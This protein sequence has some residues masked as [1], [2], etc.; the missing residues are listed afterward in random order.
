MK[1]EVI[2]K[3]AIFIAIIAIIIVAL[4]GVIY[5]L[6]KNNS[7]LRSF[8]RKLLPFTRSAVIPENKDTLKF[9][10]KSSGLMEAGDPFYEAF[11]DIE[12]E[13]DPIE[14][15]FE[16]DDLE[17]YRDNAGPMQPFEFPELNYGTGTGTGAPVAFDG[18]PFANTPGTPGLPDF[19]QQNEGAIA[20][21]QPTVYLPSVD[22]QNVHD[23]GVNK[24]IRKI[25]N[26]IGLKMGSGTR[27]VISKL[28]K[29]IPKGR[30][31][32]RIGKVLD[33]IELRNAN[34]SNL[35]NASE[36]DVLSTVYTQALKNDNIRDMMFQQ[37]E[38]AIDNGTVVCPTGVVNR[39]STALIVETP[40]QFPKTKEQ[41][42][43]EML[44]SASFVRSQ[45]EKDSSYEYMS[46]PEQSTR[47]K[48]NL[49]DKLKDDYNGI[50]TDTEI[51]DY[52]RD[53]IDHI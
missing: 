50:L 1:T 15:L 38:D 10:V 45:L 28:K 46:D 49:I 31:S 22:A 48:S 21:S 14:F 2:V 26:D 12:M 11:G 9:T 32:D 52:T 47:L 27:Q 37:L 35:N 6:Y 41:I 36:L 25:F 30:N 17:Y 39:L 42:K 33:Q 51:S 53:W 8:T 29:L 20:P 7:S 43:R 23:S 13:H 19:L 3:F 24:F 16:E 34:I 4:S 18:I 5:Y 40:E 44:E